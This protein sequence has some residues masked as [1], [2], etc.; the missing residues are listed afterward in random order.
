MAIHWQIPFKSLRSGTVYTV[1]IH[2]SGYSGAAVVLNG[3]ADPFTTQEDDSDDMF[4]PIRT[5]SGYLRIVDNGYA[6][7][8]TT[9]FDWLSFL[10][11]TDTDRPVTLTDGSGNIVWQGF[12][13]AQNFGGTL[14]GN[15][16]VREF[17][18]QCPL[19][20]LEGYDINSQN[21]EIRNFA[22]LLQYI[23]SQIPELTFSRIIIQG[24]SDAQEWLLK[25]IDWQN[26]CNLSS[27][28]EV[29]PRYNLYQC[30][31]DMCRFWG[32]TA[33]TSGQNLYLVCPD[34]SGESNFLTLTPAQL[35]TMAGGTAAGTV[36]SGFS[37]VTGSV[38]FCNTNNEDFLQRGPGKATV[39]ADGNSADETVIGFPDEKLSKD[40][41]ALGWQSWVITDDVSYRFTVDMTTFTRPLLT[42]SAVAGSASFNL[43]DAGASVREATEGL[44]VIRIKKSYSAGM[45]YASL[46]TVY[47]HA[48]DDG[49]FSLI[50]NVYRNGV[51]YE[52]TEN[53]GTDVG[54]KSMRMR[55][56]IGATRATAVWYTGSSWSS[57]VSEFAVTIGNKDDAFQ[58]KSTTHFSSKTIDASGQRGLIF[59]EFLG[60]E[61][62]DQT[63]GQRSFDIEGFRLEFERNATYNIAGAP[64]NGHWGGAANWVNVE[65]SDRREY[66]SKGT[67]HVRMDWNADCIFAT[68]NDMGYGFGVL[69][70]PD[71]TYMGG[72]SYDGVVQYPEQHLADRVTAYWALSKRRMQLELRSDLLGAVLPDQTMTVDGTYLYPIAVGHEWR[73]DITRLTLLQLI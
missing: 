61:D 16:Q 9:A 26:F 30:L 57:T 33:R 36:T 69:I 47:Q 66:V 31:E 44:G 7:N 59:I 50:G 18:V 56:G 40:M 23:I 55:F 38:E 62:A 72:A 65:R 14:Y 73:D 11:S 37:P 48:Y 3:G 20:I 46:Q 49:K 63:D 8:G 17:P 45:T 34:D 27:D 71:G 60:S 15:P 67:V 5:H 22:Y 39:T 52:S 29:E 41:K 4:T 25:C 42:G 53:D 13:Q 32:W 2:Q 6:A 10:P 28:G 19:A 1:N 54:N 43:M 21:K 70:N 24:G 51:R 58:V 12:M 68:D 35:E 64:S